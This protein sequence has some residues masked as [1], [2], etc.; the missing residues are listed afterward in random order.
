MKRIYR[1]YKKTVSIVNET[2]TGRYRNLVGKKKGF[3]LESYDKN[4]DRY[5]FFG[6]EPEE[7]ISSKGQSL[8][9][10]KKD[11]TEDV[12]EGNPLTLLKEYYNE[13]E[14][15]KDNEELNFSGGLVGSVG[16][17]FVRYSEVLPEENPD[18]IGIETVQLMLMKEFIVVD[19]VAE[20][21]TA[22]ILESDD[23]TGKET[24]AKK[25]AE[26]IKTAMQEQKEKA[27]GAR[28]TTNYM[29][30]EETVY[31]HIDPTITS[32][33]V[34]YDRL[35]HNSKISVL[36]TEEEVVSALTDGQTGTIIV[37]ET[38]F[39]ATMGG[40]TAD[41]GTITEGDNEF[42][43]KDTIH[44]QGGRIGHVGVV[45]KGMFKVGDTVTLTVDAANRQN[46]GK[47]HSATHLLQKA[48][49]IVL[50]SHVEQAGSYVDAE[51]LRFDFT[52][53]SAMTDE[54]IAKVEAIVNEQI[55]KNL[56]VV[57][58]EM[59]VEDAKKTGAMALF[60]EKYGD[61]VRVVQMKA[62]GEEAFS[63]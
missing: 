33:F 1:V 39:Y 50:G 14:I 63:V 57:T 41:K 55:A 16:Y 54:E 10:T 3:L 36:T 35:T 48:L 27:R 42:A 19:H 8:V 62:D 40:Q 24:A 58:E 56:Q 46:T 28:K 61:K 17:D 4:Y 13:F 52:H 44:L 59:S 22:V 43:V 53:F 51:R 18:E 12:R 45:T 20:T 2:A 34:G 26:L 23:E 49:R 60:G 30:A 11:G 47:N 29:G 7:I 9:I 32:K 15:R 38:P 6:V 25:A 5:T 31:Q 21:L 37:D